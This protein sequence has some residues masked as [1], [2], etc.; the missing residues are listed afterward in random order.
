MVPCASR[1]PRGRGGAVFLLLLTL[2]QAA[3]QAREPLATP[4]VRDVILLGQEGASKSTV[5]RRVLFRDGYVYVSGEPGF[6]TVDARDP[7]NLLL[8]SDWD[9]SSPKMNGSALRGAVLYV[10]NWSPGEGLLVFDV[11]RPERPA[12][13]KAVATLA[14]T[15]DVEISGS[16]LDVSIDDGITT[17]ISTYDLSEPTSPRVLG[18]LSMGDRLVG[19][20]ARR[21]ACLY[22][23]HKDW[24]RVYAAADP[25]RPSF[26]REIDL[27][28]LGGEARVRGDYLFVLARAV[29]P[30]HA[31]GVR[32]FSLAD[33][34]S[35]REVE[36]WEQEEPRDMHFQGDLLVVP[37]SG[38][39]IYT[40]DVS[41]PRDLRVAAH[42]Y[43]S[44]PGMGHGGYPVTAGGEGTHVFIGTT[45][46]NDASCEDFACDRFGARLYSV[47]IA[48]EPPR[49]APVVPDPDEATVGEEY[50]RRLELL[51]GYPAPT[52][53]V[54]RGPAGTRVD[55]T[56]L[57]RGW[58]PPAEDAGSVHPI[59]VRSANPDGEARISWQVVVVAPPD[60]RIAL[61]DF[62]EGTEGWTLETWKSGPYE[63]GEM[64]WEPSGGR[65]GG[66][67]FSRGSGATNNEDTC[68]REGGG[69]DEG[70]LH[71]RAHADPPRA[72]LL[73]RPRAAAGLLGHGHVRGPG[74]DERRRAR[75]L[76][77]A[78]G[79]RRALEAPRPPLRGR[80][81]AGGLDAEGDRPLR[82]RRPRRQPPVRRPL[83]L[84]VQHGGRLGTDRQRR[85]AGAGDRGKLRPGGR[86]GRGE[87][88]HLRPHRRPQ[89]PLLG[90]RGRLPRCRRRERLRGR[91]HLRCHLRPVVRLPRRS[92]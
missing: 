30:G 86:H 43:V 5:S 49:I 23:T 45:T 78:G 33:P 70:D 68:N 92:E 76:R 85:R 34:A 52:W 72:R 42:W 82:P 79:G 65:E 66:C 4:R 28:G 38:S 54:V 55:A 12:R 53:S 47:Q 89:L 26:V 84:A 9:Q 11:A 88:R 73:L 71:G 2:S 77:V 51:E 67:L 46:G 8:A 83:P 39:G 14:H 57:V 63:P 75:R 40:I 81:P 64:R 7:G 90:R 17:G 19:N 59:E 56:G 13:V 37:A 80:R 32:V 27:G 58:T 60:D 69:R 10:A 74:G 29:A 50:L 21:G 18:F 25:S 48:T 44:W 36:R 41:D 6:Q 15:W 87:D 3:L 16:L 1:L 22:V 24:L 31:G 20:A 35:P 91:R 61:F 62:E